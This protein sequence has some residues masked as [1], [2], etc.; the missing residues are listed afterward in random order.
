MRLKMHVAVLFSLLL[1]CPVVAVGAIINSGIVDDFNEWWQPEDLVVASIDNLDGAI[2]GPLSGDNDSQ[3]FF[4]DRNPEEAFFDD[5]GLNDQIMPVKQCFIDVGDGRYALACI[6]DP[7]CPSI[8][9]PGTLL[10][11][12]SGLIGLLAGVRCRIGRRQKG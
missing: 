11:F 1:L 8:P 7:A 6:E 9:V 5:P 3:I 2:P 12:S 10:L 4:I